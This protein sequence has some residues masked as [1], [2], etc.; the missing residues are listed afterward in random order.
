MTIL[1]NL[2]K[3]YRRLKG[4]PPEGAAD[5]ASVFRFKYSQFKELLDA[6]SEILNIIT[7]MEEK[8]KGDQLF[9]MAYIRSQATRAAFYAF[10]MIKSLNVLANNRYAELYQILENINRQIKEILAQEPEPQIPALILPLCDV[11]RDLAEWVG[12]K[13]ANLGEMRNRLN[14]PV[15]TGFAITTAACRQFFA[16]GNLGEDI[17][18]RLTILEMEDP[19]A[20]EAISQEIQA[21]ILAAPLPDDLAAAITAAYQQLATSLGRPAA[22]PQAPL[23]SL[24]SSAIG[25]DSDFSFA[26]QYLT[27]LNVTP[28]EILPAY[29]KVLASLYTARAIAYRLTKG[30]REEDLAMAVLCL[31]M[32]PAVASGV[33]YTRDPVNPTADYLLISAVWGLGPYAVD[34]VITPDIYKVRRTEPLSILD[35][36]VA[37]KP[38][39]LVPRAEGGVAEQPVP[40][41]QQE[42]P[43]LTEEQILTL[44]AYARRLE[45]YYHQP[46]DLE[47]A[48]A[49]DGRLLL[50][51]SRPLQLP[52]GAMLLPPDL[53]LDQY[54]L[55]AAGGTV[56]QPGVGC[57]PAFILRDDRE[58]ANFPAGAVLVARHSSPKYALVMRRAQAIITE[59]G[60]IS[61]HMAAVARELGVPTLMGVTAATTKITPGQEITVDAYQGRVFAGRV[62]ELLTFQQPRKI[63]LQ[64]TPVYQTLQQVAALIVPLNLI[65]P[66]SPDFRPDQCRTLHDLSRLVHEFSYQVMFQVSDLVTD[67]GGGAVKLEAPVPLDL[68][69][70]DLGQGLRDGAAGRR[71]VTPE[72]I[73]SR[74]FQALLRGMLHEELREYGPRP[75]NLAGFLSVMREQMLSTP[76]ERFGDRSYA[77]I[78]A[79]YLNFSSRVGYHYSVLDAYCGEPMNKNYITFS[80][81]GGAADE[82]RRNRRARAIAQVLM[83]ENFQVEVTGDRVFARLQKYPAE[84]IAAKLE[85]IGRLLQFTRQ[86]DMLMHTEASVDWIAHNFLAGN[87]RLDQLTP[88]PAAAHSANPGK[89]T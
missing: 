25:E 58:L 83:A 70:I 27:V 5:A 28:E 50:L 75:V 23:V 33:I 6:N 15:P 46:Q 60:N 85:M 84:V 30:L 52:A 2:K 63:K 40:A 32:V 29:R 9:G 61:G 76:G 62:T 51:Q 80:F 8:L 81:K 35:L 73:L 36:A 87:Y 65:D 55:L 12:G 41:D 64:D 78:G 1:E 68:Y 89:I 26:G 59:A 37:P 86:M 21:A 43:C 54:Q 38:V 44:A 14:L 31:E 71:R 47:W 48:L 7:D 77:I 24:R 72:D 42:S 10:R 88:P 56:A 4:L 39:R 53:Q 3:L 19:A 13:A 49:P 16:A 57:G 20:I 82:V 18:R 45:D 74:P 79:E 67:W 34:G 69:I 66:Q 17:R 22:G 11:T